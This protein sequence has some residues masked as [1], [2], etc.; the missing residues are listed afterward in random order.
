MPPDEPKV[1]VPSLANETAFATA[2]LE[3]LKLTFATVLPT[4]RLVI[5]EVPENVAVPPTLAKVKVVTPP[6]FPDAVMLAL[7]ILFSVVNVK[8]FELPVTA[9]N[10]ISPVDVLVAFVSIVT[11]LP[12][13][14]APKVSASS[15]L[16]IDVFKVTVPATA[17]V[18]KPPLKVKLS[19]VALPK[20][21]L[22]SLAKVAAPLKVLVLPVKVILATVLLALKVAN[23]T[24]LLKLAVPP[25]SVSV[26]LPRPL[27]APSNA[28]SVLAI[29]LPVDKLKLFEPPVIAPSVISPVLFVEFASIVTLLPKVTAPKLNASLLL[30]KVP[31]KVTV[32]PTLV[33]TNASPLPA[34]L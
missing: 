30:L 2:K 6:I 1:S 8:V 23:A 25:T 9:P 27:I 33:V 12:K 34:L 19:L 18:F 21:K 3:L 10:V 26:K 5:L 20:I 16:L 11:L 28:M 7:A 17:D 13:L 15:E 31:F 24:L 4:E 22:A 29:L 32:P 14:I